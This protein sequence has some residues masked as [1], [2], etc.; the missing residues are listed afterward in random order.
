MELI[1]GVFE[2]AEQFMEKPKFVKINEEQ[3]KKIAEQMKDTGITPFP[4][5][6]TGEDEKII[7][8][9][10]LAAS[11]INFC[12]FYGSSNIRPKGSSSTTMYELLNECIDKNQD[13]KT[14]MAFLCSALSTHRFPLVQ[15]RINNIAEVM[16]YGEQYVL[17]VYF[18]HKNPKM[19]EFLFKNL[20]AIFPGYGS[21]MFLKRASLFF[22]Q[23]NRRL[24]YF[25][26]MMT[27]LPVPA[28][29]QVPNMMRHFGC[30]DYS[31][32]LSK[33]IWEGELIPKHSRMECEI[34]SATVLVGRTL[35]EL[36][37]WKVADIDGWFW[38]RRKETS[39]PFH[40]TITTDY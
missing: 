23:L 24:G 26:E 30:I 31:R 20:I 9:K 27:L 16:V 39:L 10:E 1:N 11:A 35:Q 2:L 18:H 21:D 29:Y 37:G 38:L 3:T 40:L 36:T 13:F 19:H 12:Y 7:I 6:S 5:E 22:L 4:Y 17:D 25:D 34:R 14:G 8:L 33:L 28:D 15:E 32:K